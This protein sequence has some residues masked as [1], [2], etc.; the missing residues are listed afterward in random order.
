M[1]EKEMR[2]LTFYRGLDP[3]DQELIRLLLELA[4]TIKRLHL[5]G[6]LNEVISSWSEITS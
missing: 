4:S 1:T 3:E 2:F 6:K 5:E